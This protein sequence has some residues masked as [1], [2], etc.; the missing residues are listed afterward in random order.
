[1]KNEKKKNLCRNLEISYCLICIVRKEAV[2][3]YSLLVL[4]CIVGCKAKLYC[5]TKL[6]CN[7]RGLEAGSSVLQYTA[8]YCNTLH[9]IAT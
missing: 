4:D 5:K 3:Q 2:L 9:C 6:Y 1:M 8:L 7:R